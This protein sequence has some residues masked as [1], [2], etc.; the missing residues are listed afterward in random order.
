MIWPSA[1]F[2]SLTIIRIRLTT[3]FADIQR[4]TPAHYL[5]WQAGNLRLWR[6]WDLPLI[7]RPLRYSHP[8]DYVEHFKALLTQAVA[9][10]LRTRRVGVPMSGGLDSSTVAALAREVLRRQSVPFDLQGYT[11]VYDRLI[12]DEERYYSRLVANVLGIPVG[13]SACR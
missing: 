6:Y 8:Q 5:T 1:I 2:F 13:P 12:P 11:N 7:E 10:R 9:D 3:T 4:L